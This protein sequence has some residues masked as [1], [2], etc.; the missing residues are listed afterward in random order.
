MRH[1]HLIEIE[2][3]PWLPASVRNLLTDFLT[4]LSTRLH[5]YRSVRPLL[6]EVLAKTGTRQVIDLCSGAAG[7]WLQL[8][9]DGFDVSVILT[10]K[11]PNRAAMNLAQQQHPERITIH[12]NPVDARALPGDC[13]GMFTMF[14]GFH[15]FRP[16]EAKAILQSVSQRRMAICIFEITE[17]SPRILLSV[18]TVPILMLLV[19]PWLRPLTW[20]RLFWTYL[21][22]LAP[23][24]LL[25]DGLVSMLRIYSQ[26]DLQGL[27]A[28]TES[29]DYVWKTG[30]LTPP[31]PAIPITYLIGYPQ[32]KMT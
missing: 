31:F 5:I 2:D 7:P 29:P 17:T 11:Y 18:L 12:E 4:F 23:L 15:H 14:N 1:W 6:E 26:Q 28:A 16:A 21:I 32:T 25:W 3:L 10:D 20:S 8:L 30:R 24:C 27:A 9:D 22:P 13:K 19:T